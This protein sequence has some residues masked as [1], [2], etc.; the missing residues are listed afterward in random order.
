MRQILAR[1][2]HSSTSLERIMYAFL[3]CVYWSTNRRLTSDHLRSA[4]IPKLQIGCGS[5]VLPGWLNADVRSQ[6][7]VLSVDATKRLPFPNAS[8]RFVFSEHMIEHITYAQG[9]RMLNEIFRVLTS[10]GRIRIATPDMAFLVRLYREDSS[11]SHRQYVEWAAARFCE[12]QPATPVSVINN[13]FHNWG[14]QYIYDF[15]TLS[16]TLY[17]I[18]FRNVVR[19]APGESDEPSLRD[20]ESHGKEVGEHFNQLETV[21]VEA[22]KP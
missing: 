3:A 6:R 2:A 7:D 8:F 20:L 10:G 11:E 19:Y 1:I 12:G 21:V 18:G 9:Y 17:E 5:Y 16:T 14:H 13:F 22:E 15:P 4:G